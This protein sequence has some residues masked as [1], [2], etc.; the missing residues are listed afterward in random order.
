MVKDKTVI[1]IQI[2][3]IL[4]VDTVEIMEKVVVQDSIEFTSIKSFLRFFAELWKE[5][6]RIDFRFI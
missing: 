4:E 2:S 3:R 1:R 5:F 6:I